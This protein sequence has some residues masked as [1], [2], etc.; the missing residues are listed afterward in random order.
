MTSHL[1]W[2]LRRWGNWAHRISA[3]RNYRRERGSPWEG[4]G[5]S[6][7][8]GQLPLVRRRFQSR[9]LVHLLHLFKEISRDSLG[10]SSI[11]TNIRN[12]ELR[13]EVFISWLNRMGPWMTSRT[14][15]HVFPS[16]I[17]RKD[18]APKCYW[19]RQTLPYMHIGWRSCP[20]QVLYIVDIRPTTT[21]HPAP[22][23]R[24]RPN[25]KGVFSGPETMRCLSA[26]IPSEMA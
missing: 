6:R 20:H 1:I 16:L 14:R 19:F 26:L 11:S 9:L 17:Y 8:S 5:V 10:T 2:P 3:C 23:A 18:V 21:S 7:K 15:G 12:F 25:S 4:D 22:C 24:R 13:T